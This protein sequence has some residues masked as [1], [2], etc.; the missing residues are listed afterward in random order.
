MPSVDALEWR[1]SSFTENGANCVEVAL[2][3][4]V[5]VRDSKAPSGGTLAFPG[6]AWQG[7]LAS[8]AE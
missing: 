7:L 8:I 2:T 1:T 6:T 4:E 3:T 5:L